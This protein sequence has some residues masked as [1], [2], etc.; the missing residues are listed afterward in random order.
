MN[1]SLSLARA[2]ADAV[3][4]EGYLLYPYRASSQKNQSRW[5]FGILGP[6]GAALAG[7]GEEPDMFADC[8][9]SPGPLAEM[10]V[11]LR[12]LQLQTRTAEKADDGGGFSPL[13]ELT[14][15]PKRWLS[16]DEAIE[17]E[18]A[19][20]PFSVAELTGE[21]L[22]LPVEIE[23]GIDVEDLDSVIVDPEAAGAAPLSGRLV[24]RRRALHGEVR[25][26][27]TDVG[28]GLVRLRMTAVNTAAALPEPIRKQ[29]AIANSFIGTHLLLSAQDADFVS[30][31]EPPDEALQAA[32]SCAQHR[33]WPVLAGPEGQRDVLLVS[34]IIL[35]DHPAVAPESS[36]ALYDSTEIDEI[37][38]LRVLT[39][40][41]EEKAEAR[42]TDPRVAAI[43]DR[44]EAMSPEELQQLHGILRNP[45][46]LAEPALAEASFGEPL[47]EWPEAR[48]PEGSL[49]PDAAEDLPWWEP[50]AEAM[51]QPE[52]DAV[53][54]NGVPVARGSR[55]RVNPRRRADAQDL[56]FAG[57][58]G[59]VTSVHF[60]VD[61]S[62]HVGLVLEQDPAADLHE[63]YGRSFYYAPDELEPLEPLETLEPLPPG[64]HPETQEGKE[65]P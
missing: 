64:S 56:F 8:I 11:H 47:L 65:G 49:A 29:D 60:D 36:V 41:Q 24:R 45:H 62:T 52:A 16:W 63:D 43:I 14:I 44:C 4:Y 42:A 46:S 5:Q 9:L 37:L 34:P 48:T 1:M 28:N 35:Y 50:E 61:G 26:Q 18:V 30:Q 22:V 17:H 3:L 33:C 27:A 32:Q 10:E 53:V 6:P 23:G 31:L 40:T 38:T 54:I 2:V 20:G 59:R 55:V 15:G 51:V 21:P 39:L 7:M 13:D 57:Q 19:L 12:F 58:T 25:L